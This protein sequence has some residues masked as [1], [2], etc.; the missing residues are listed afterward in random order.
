M[1]DRI[2]KKQL[3][4]PEINRMG[5]DRKSE[6]MKAILK[7]L[8]GKIV[9]AGQ[10]LTE[11]VLAE[12]LGTTREIVTHMIGENDLRDFKKALKNKRMN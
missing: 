12:Y 11:A 9:E 5:I 8:M 2:L 6:P 4:W 1:V 3:T 7:G 10:N